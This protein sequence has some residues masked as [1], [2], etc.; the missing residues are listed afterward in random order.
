MY[1]NRAPLCEGEVIALVAGVAPVWTV[2]AVRI[3]AVERAAQ[4]FSFTLVTLPQ[5]AVTGIERFS[6][7]WADDDSVWYDL[8]AVSTPQHPLVRLGAPVLWRIQTRFA[9]DSVRSLRR[10]IA[11]SVVSSPRVR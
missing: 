4:H 2:S 11:E 9:V 5:H 10:F 1:P 7:V 3:V 8:E 6:V